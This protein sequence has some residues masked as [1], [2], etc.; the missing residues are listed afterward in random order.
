MDRYVN[1]KLLK[2]ISMRIKE[3]RSDKKITQSAF[4]EDT[5]INIGRIERGV[6]DV[7]ISNLHRICEYF[8]LSLEEFFKNID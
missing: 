5:G 1:K 8:E 4:Y 7:S 2:G 3:L 6:N